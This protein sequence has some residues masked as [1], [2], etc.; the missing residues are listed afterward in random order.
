MKELVGLDFQRIPRGSHYNFMLITCDRLKQETGLVKKPLVREA[1]AALEAALAA[2]AAYFGQPRKSLLTDEIKAADAERDRLY[3]G[4][5]S[6][7]KAFLQVPMADA[8]AAARVLWQRIKDHRIEGRM[9]LDRET[10]LMMHMLEECT[11][12]YAAQVARLGLTEY[13]AA[14]K[15]ADDRLHEL[16]LRRS[17]D[18]AARL[19]G[20][21]R[22]ARLV[23]DA[24]FRD[25]VRVVNSIAVVEGE[26]VCA[27]FIGYMN[28]LVREYKQKVI[29]GR[30]RR[31]VPGLEPAE[32]VAAEPTEVPAVE[33][34][35]A[36]EEVAAE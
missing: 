22:L 5:K 24:R 3:A 19:S 13:V 30:R 16:T 23:C 28:E 18:R 32:D 8:A 4:Y 27:P 29:R 25:L 12:V 6:I 26:A 11:T 2:E 15:A 21:L 1:L 17:D 9:Q 34:V 14:L 33:A 10:G 36:V 20:T 35:E 31:V 7:V